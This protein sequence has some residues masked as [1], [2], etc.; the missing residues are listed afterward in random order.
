MMSRAYA[1]AAETAAAAQ[2]REPLSVTIDVAAILSTM[3][4][5]IVI[6]IILFM[7][8]EMLP[9]LR[10]RL[11][12]LV[13]ELAG[14]AIKVGVGG[15]TL[16]FAKAKAFAPA[17]S[18]PTAGI[19]LRQ[20]AGVMQVTDNTAATFLDQLRDPAPADYAIVNVGT[21]DQWLTSRLYIMAVILARM[22]DLKA[23]VFLGQS[24]SSRRY[25]G[26][27]HPN[28]VRWALARRYPWLEAAYAAAYSHVAA[29]PTIR[30]TSRSGRLVDTNLPLDDPRPSL[31][32]LQAFLQSIQCPS[33][34]MVAGFAP[35]VAPPDS[36]ATDWVIVDEQR[37]IREHAV[38]LNSALLE[39]ILGDELDFSHVAFDALQG[40]T[41]SEQNRLVLGQVGVA[42][43]R[44]ELRF[45][46][47]IDRSILLAQMADA[48]TAADEA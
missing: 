48:V 27:T 28:S 19:D 6:L 43:T 1:A 7:L 37:S 3:V 12:T 14:R 35:T 23:F 47:L 16:E 40:K 45:E 30:V 25:L 39:D 32:L 38:W 34:P 10:A 17:F 44:E 24:S 4:W 5:L 9:D 15:F 8:R 20:R 13:R 33:E 22:K 2:A 18:S 41:R 36:A 42:V 26:W 21:G 46:Y 29:R 31:D 11:P